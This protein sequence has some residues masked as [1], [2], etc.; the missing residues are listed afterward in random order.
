M[1]KFLPARTQRRV[2]MR[3]ARPAH[4]GTR[5]SPVRRQRVHPGPGLARVAAQIEL[6]HAARLCVGNVRQRQSVP[7]ENQDRPP[8]RAPTQC[9]QASVDATAPA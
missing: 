7:V 4:R 3:L 9:P 6:R 1:K 8:T 5:C 2:D